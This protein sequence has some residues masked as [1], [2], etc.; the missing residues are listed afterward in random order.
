MIE[1]IKS[2][3][4]KGNIDWQKH[5]LERMLQRGISRENVKTA[6]LE[7]DLVNA[8]PED[9]PYSSCLVS[10]KDGADVYH[11]VVAYDDKSETCFII[12]VYRPDPRY[13]ESDLKTRKK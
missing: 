6:L 13:F 12:T 4:C 9:K 11:V 3:I 2:A 7:G 8:Y 5:A 1:K 10:G